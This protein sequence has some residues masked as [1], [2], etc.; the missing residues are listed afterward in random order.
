MM[1]NVSVDGAR[2]TVYTIW[3]KLFIVYIIQFLVLRDLYYVKSTSYK[4]KNHFK[5][6]QINQTK[7]EKIKP[8]FNNEY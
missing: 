1:H 3:L 8:N 2:C 6:T 4:L 5:N 7:I